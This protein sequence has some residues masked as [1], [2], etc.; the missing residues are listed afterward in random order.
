MPKAHIEITKNEH[1]LKLKILIKQ[2][3]AWEWWYLGVCSI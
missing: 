3:N 2:K 1:E